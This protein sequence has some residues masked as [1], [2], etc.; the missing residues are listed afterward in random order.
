[1]HTLHTT[2][3]SFVRCIIPNELKQ[4]GIETLPPLPWLHRLTVT[5][6]TTT[7]IA[8]PLSF[9]R[10]EDDCTP[11][12]LWWRRRAFAHAAP[13]CFPSPYTPSSALQTRSASVVCFSST[14][15]CWTSR[16]RAATPMYRPPVTPKPALRPCS[17]EWVCRLLPLLYDDD[18]SCETPSR[19]QR[20]VR[21]SSSVCP[22]PSHP[23]LC[24]AP[25]VM[26]LHVCINVAFMWQQLTGAV[27]QADGDAEENN[28]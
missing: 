5:T 23:A 25:V 26:C 3:P 19:R 14:C 20:N 12:P 2:S 10:C 17:P 24:Y 4:S 9:L 11:C 28:A 8:M 6:T 15:T 22:S 13:K 16:V 21:P 18:M 7:P 1:M 27:K